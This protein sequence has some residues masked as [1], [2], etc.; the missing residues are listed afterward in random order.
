MDATAYNSFFRNQ[1]LAWT[2][3]PDDSHLLPLKL[4]KM[5][6]LLPMKSSKIEENTW[7]WKP[8]DK[9]RWRKRKR[10]QAKPDASPCRSTIS[11]RLNYGSDQLDT[12]GETKQLTP[13]VNQSSFWVSQKPEGRS[14]M[15]TAPPTCLLAE[16]QVIHHFF[17]VEHG[18]HF[19]N[20]PNDLFQMQLYLVIAVCEQQSQDKLIG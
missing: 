19:P 15:F 8:S 4:E 9:T 12:K 17:S 1:G 10:R 6:H 14:S 20:R 16:V 5:F 2:F 18:I 3:S 11:L 7:V 13:N